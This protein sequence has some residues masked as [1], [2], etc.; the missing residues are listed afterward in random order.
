MAASTNTTVALAAPEA[1]A[2]DNTLG[3]VLIGTFISL[4]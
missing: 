1:L 3:A 4:V 2:L